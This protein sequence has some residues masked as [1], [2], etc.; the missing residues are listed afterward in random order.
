[1]LHSPAGKTSIAQHSWWPADVFGCWD[2]GHQ[3]W[4]CLQLISYCRVWGG[5]KLAVHKQWSQC[6]CSCVE[7]L[8]ILRAKLHIVSSL[9]TVLK[10]D[11]DAMVPGPHAVRWRAWGPVSQ[12]MVNLKS[13]SFVVI[14]LLHEGLTHIQSQIK[15]GLLLPRASL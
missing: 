14:L 15:P 6:W 9:L 2:A 8:V 4:M 1:M 7:T 5:V 3:H 11:F 12:T 13:A 10:K